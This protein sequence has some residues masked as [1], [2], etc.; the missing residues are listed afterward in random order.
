MRRGFGRKA[1]NRRAILGQAISPPVAITRVTGEG[2]SITYDTSPGSYFNLWATNNPT[3]TTTKRAVTSAGIGNSTD[4]PGTNSLWGRKATVIADNPQLLTILIG[5]N[6]ITQYA[7]VDGSGSTASAPTGDWLT[8]LYEYIAYMKVQIPG[9]KVLVASGT[10]VD[11]AA[12]PDPTYGGAVVNTRRAIVRPLL[13]A[14]VGSQ[15]DG[16]IPFGDAMANNFF[17][18]RLVSYDGIHPDSEGRALMYRIFA[19]VMDPII[20]GATG[21]NPSA[22]TLLDQ[23]N[24]PLGGTATA[25]M[26][27]TGLGMGQTATA[28]VSGGRMKRGAGAFGTGNLS[29]MNGD[30]I[31]VE[32]T[33]SAVTNEATTAVT[34][35]VG[36]R[37]ATFTARAAA[38]S[39]VGFTHSTDARLAGNSVVG[40]DTT[41][42]NVAFP[43]GRPIVMISK[44]YNEVTSVT[45]NGVAAAEVGG[46]NSSNGYFR[47]FIGP[48]G[49]NLAAGNYTVVVNAAYWSN[50]YCA[51]Y[52]ACV[53]NCAQTAASMLVRKFNWDYYATSPILVASA[54]TPSGALV[55]QGI[56][57]NEA[58]NPA[59]HNGAWAWTSPSNTNNAGN[60][61]FNTKFRWGTGRM[62][63]QQGIHVPGNF[64]AGTVLV[65]QPT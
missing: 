11:E 39:P 34:L 57:F 28:S 62:S 65:L 22:F 45:I 32:A 44:P 21:N 55:L 46:S 38:A 15:I 61:G 16:F 1:A 33:V 17:D 54:P 2:D 10:P 43:A 20:A 27:V 41:F 40:D 30:I 48:P 60:Q 26:V 29:V 35:T 24:V 49:Q 56:V 23:N 3:I 31:T 63:G 64:N 5:A 51:L 50:D 12:W 6:D 25:E 14:A 53:T 58:V 59:M 37:T 8:K 42:T 47:M 13:R 4:A 7:T 52:P 18:D 19:A 36:A 9:L